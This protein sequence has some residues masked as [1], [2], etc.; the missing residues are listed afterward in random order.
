MNH[1]LKIRVPHVFSMMANIDTGR[2]KR[3]QLKRSR[4]MKNCAEIADFLKYQPLLHRATDVLWI[5]Y[6]TKGAQSGSRCHR[7]TNK[8]RPPCH[9]APTQLKIENQKMYAAEDVTVSEPTAN[10]TP[11]RLLLINNVREGS[12]DR[13]AQ[14]TWRGQG[15]RRPLPARYRR[16]DGSRREQ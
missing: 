10:I 2:R 5:L 6:K 14:R 11:L 3:K 13:H 7:I 8:L 15:T 1:Q 9:T 12:T 4:M 16:A